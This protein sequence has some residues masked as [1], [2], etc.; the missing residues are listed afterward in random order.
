M[1]VTIEDAMV[2]PFVRELVEYGEARGEAK[3]EAKAVLVILDGREIPVPLAARQRILACAD[4]ETL[5]T[6]IDRSLT[7]TSVDELFD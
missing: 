3:G 6:W 5:E 1:N 4:Q 2:H 7:A